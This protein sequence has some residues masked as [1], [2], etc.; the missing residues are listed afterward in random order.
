MWLRLRS[1]MKASHFEMIRAQL[2]PLFHGL[3]WLPETRSD[4]MWN[5][6]TPTESGWTFLGDDRPKRG[7]RIIVNR[8]RLHHTQS[9]VLGHA[10]AEE[11]EEDEE[12]AEDINDARRQPPPPRRSRSHQRRS[13]SL[14]PERMPRPGGSSHP[15]A[16]RGL[17]PASANRRTPGP[18]GGHRQAFQFQQRNATPS[19]SRLPQQVRLRQQ[20]EEEEEEEDQIPRF[21]HHNATASSSRLPPHVAAMEEEEEEEED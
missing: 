8:R 17:S 2:L 1:L 11:E 5:T 19:S 7:V 21:G 15:S 3:L 12:P 16:R 6:K 14:D 20:E 10:I 4:R 9:I 13:A 18:S